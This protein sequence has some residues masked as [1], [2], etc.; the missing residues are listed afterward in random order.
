MTNELNPNSRAALDIAR[1]IIAERRI[2]PTFT[3]DALMIECR[4]RDYRAAHPTLNIDPDR[5]LT[6]IN[7]AIA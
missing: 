6:L 3:P 5:T 1:D 4:I 7:F 2:N